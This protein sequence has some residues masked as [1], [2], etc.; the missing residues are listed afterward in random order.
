MK[1]RRVKSKRLKTRSSKEKKAINQYQYKRQDKPFEWFQAR[2]FFLRWWTSCKLEGQTGLLCLPNITSLDPKDKHCIDDHIT[3]C[4]EF[5]QNLWADFLFSFSQM[6]IPFLSLLLS[7]CLR[8]Q[9]CFRDRRLSFFFQEQDHDDDREGDEC[10]CCCF[11]LWDQRQRSLTKNKVMMMVSE[12]DDGSKMMMTV[13]MMMISRKEEYI[14]GRQRTT[15]RFSCLTLST[16]SSESL[17]KTHKRVWES[18]QWK[19]QS[20]KTKG[21]VRWSSCSSFLVYNI[22]SLSFLF[23]NKNK[24]GWEE[25]KKILQ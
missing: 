25:K 22:L 21:C 8:F 6:K 10:V 15:K 17:W 3:T 2:F 23:C 14:V 7:G 9:D 16:K 4:G 24:K 1:R 19:W 20:K 18:S 11:F 5:W 12:E 13:M